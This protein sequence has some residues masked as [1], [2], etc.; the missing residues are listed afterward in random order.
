VQAGGLGGVIAR[1]QIIPVTQVGFVCRLLMPSG[2][3]MLRGLCMVLGR[4][5]KILGCFSVMEDC[6]IR[7]VQI[8]F[9]FPLLPSRLRHSCDS[10]PALGAALVFPDVDITTV[11]LPRPSANWLLPS[12]DLARDLTSRYGPAPQ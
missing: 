8:S 3:K 7:H 6:I 12:R 9:E 10:C 5:C 4:R 1:V 11:T 2:A